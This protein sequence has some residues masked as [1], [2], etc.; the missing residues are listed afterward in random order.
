VLPL[1]TAALL[2]LVTTASFL[3]SQWWVFDLASHVR[4][5][6]LAASLIVLLAVAFAPSRMALGLSIVAVLA[7]AVPLGPYLANVGRA[8]GTMQPDLR[9][10][11][12]NL[13]G[14][15]TAPESF[16]ALIE[17]EG[18][19]VVL[20]TELPE[21]EERLLAPL[22]ARYPYRVADRRG[23]PFDVALLS[24][25]TI[26]T[27]SIDRE[28][29]SFLPVLTAR[30]CH[31]EREMQ[32]LTLIGLHAAR[33]FG[34]GVRLQQ[35]QLRLAAKAA[36]AAPGRSALVMGDLNLTLWSA[37]FQRFLQQAGLSAGPEARGLETTWLSRFP[38]LGLTIDHVLA[39]PGIQVL[40]A[41]VGRDVGSDH[42]PVI[43]HLAL[44]P[45]P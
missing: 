18:P 27:W 11:T 2:A 21:D 22:S 1:I 15:D 17:A 7:N 23:S 24:E 45:H 34:G 25:W 32:C 43:A 42:L 38:L 28:A 10:M 29:A 6:L 12:L 3:G 30:L 44:K 13:H 8:Y 37:T 40:Q 16:T 14:S 5:Q 4:V 39:G 20:L 19:N 9:V 41:R 35:V 33:P 36:R 26:E 31:P